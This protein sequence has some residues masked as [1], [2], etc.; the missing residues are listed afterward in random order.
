M[1]AWVQ[2][3]RCLYVRGACSYRLQG[4]DPAPATAVEKDCILLELSSALSIWR[5]KMEPGSGDGLAEQRRW[6]C[7]CYL[8]GMSW[9]ICNP[10]YGIKS[11]EWAAACPWVGLLW[12]G[13]WDAWAGRARGVFISRLCPFPSSPVSGLRCAGSRT[14]LLSL[15]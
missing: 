11:R 15:N 13:D 3:K 2:Y 8:E 9:N 12:D 4:C 5:E 10:F 1:T 6:L 7:R 14:T